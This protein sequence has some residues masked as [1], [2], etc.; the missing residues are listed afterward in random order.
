MKK[1]AI[2]ILNILLLSTLFGCRNSEADRVKQIV[3]NMTLKEKAAQMLMPSFRFREYGKEDQSEDLTSITPELEELL[4]EY[5]FGG[6]I[7][8]S[9]NIKDTDQTRKLVDDLNNASIQG[10][11][12][13]LF[14]SADQEGGAVQRIPFGTFMPGNMALGANGDSEDIYRCA[15]II[16]DE[17]KGL[18]IN[19]DF[20]PDADINLEPSNP[21]IGIRSFSDDSVTVADDLLYFMRGL[22]DQN[23]ISVIKHFPGHGNTDVDSH[24]GL[25]LIDQS[26]EQIEKAE[27]VPFDKAIKGG[28]EMIMS[29]H[30]QYPQIE[31]QTYH[32]LNG[33]EI[34]LPATLSEKIIQ[35]ILREKL[36]FDGVVITDSLSMNAIALNFHK[37]DAIR[38][39][40]NAG[41]DMMLMPVD[42]HKS[43]SLYI[44]QLKNY[45]T[46]IVNLVNE[47]LVSQER[48]DEAVTR[49][50]T[51]K[52]RHGLLDNKQEE[53]EVSIG[54]KEHHD[55]EMAIAER[56]VTLVKNDGV[57]PLSEE[58][59]VL[60]MAPYNAQTNSVKYAIQLLKAK[61]LI[62]SDQNIEVCTFG[63]ET[64]QND[65]KRNIQPF[66][67]KADKVVFLSYLYETA[68]LNGT[69]FRMIDRSLMYC[70]R[71]RIKT[72]VI[73]SHLPYDLTRFDADGL[74]ACYYAAGIKN[75]PL[76]GK[77]YP[78]NLI[79][80]L[81]VAYGD[82]RPC[83]KLPVNIPE[84][85]F[86]NGIYSYGKKI[87]YKR[88]YSIT[89]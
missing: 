58:D 67:K 1:I 57:L 69:E 15:Y 70:K 46:A 14:L 37:K 51:L 76:E 68:D 87:A 41:V 3:D 45:V 38:S 62:T 2:L 78:P 30:I 27:L 26:L 21:V 20:A 31:D 12:L 80:A 29:A 7:L 50:V 36:H 40:I 19:M 61:Q 49:I 44:L 42:D 64:S 52:L 5:G 17:L 43:T 28:V 74:M 13:P 48:I 6:I 23:L 83:G 85:V 72:I 33:E 9:N 24:T 18:H 86:K 4:K 10:G 66:L 73:S 63:F 56:A 16:G 32:S 54:S 34:Y 71:N 60:I 8:F 84:M 55:I 88:G 65:F 81:L 47:G 11:H 22:Q 75:L 25:P 82:I 77:G 53:T 59:K 79:A 89:Y 35:G 39:C